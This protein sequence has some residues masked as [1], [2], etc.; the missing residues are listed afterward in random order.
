MKAWIV[1]ELMLGAALLLSPAAGA[2]SFTVSAGGGSLCAGG[3]GQTTSSGPLA[4]A[5]SWLC[6]SGGSSAEAIAGPGTLGVGSS[7]YHF[8]CGSAS[9]SNALAK[10]ETEFEIKGP[11]GAAIPV[12]MN[13]LLEGAAVA[14]LDGFWS[15]HID[16]GLFGTGYIDWS[17]RNEG[18]L[19][20]IVPVNR[21][22]AI[23]GLFTTPTVLFDP[24]RTQPFR[25]TLYGG[26]SAAG[27]GNASLDFGH[28]LSLPTSGPVLNLPDG[29][30]V[31]MPGLFVS[32]NRF[33]PPGAGGAVPEPGSMALLGA[34]LAALAV[35]RR[36]KG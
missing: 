25:L 5:E 8:C 12:S 13:F 32:D 30:T 22:V 14:F 15:L 9:E 21:G 28:T 26:T 6:V 3:V 31:D 33:L 27:S 36:R 23:A 17:G 16:A 29:Y 1:C 10:F 18:L 7:T 4:A 2:A 35:L 20:G 11:A 34:G 19:A 24:N